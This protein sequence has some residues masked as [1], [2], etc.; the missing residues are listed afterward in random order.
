MFISVANSIHFVEV[1]TDL[2]SP[3]NVLTAD[4]K[5]A[6]YTIKTYCQRF[7]NTD[8]VTVQ[9]GSDEATVPT[10]QV[11]MPHLE[12]TIVPTLV[13]SYTTDPD[14]ANH[15]Y[16]FEFDV[17]F[18]SYS[19]A[20]QIKATQG[21]SVWISEPVKAE[22]L[23]EDLANGNLLRID[24]TNSSKPSD[25]FNFEID[26]TTG[27]QFFF[28][29]EAVLTNF[30]YP[31]EDTLTKNIDR[32]KLLESKLSRAAELKTDQLPEYMC[33]LL[34]VAASHF[35]YTI[36]GLQYVLED[37]D[38]EQVE[39]TNF[40]VLTQTVSQKDVLAFNTD[41]RGIEGFDMDIVTFSQNNNVTSTWS[42]T[43]EKERMTHVVYARHNASSVATYTFKAGTTIGGNDLISD[44]ISEVDISDKTTWR[45]FPLHYY[46]GDSNQTIYIEITGVGAIADFYVPKLLNQ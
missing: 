12:A 24:H 25:N 26:Y 34:S 23:T 10:V 3:E 4:Q 9:L 32:N 40:Q 15:R 20:I 39:F 8:T 1:N 44:F 13:S 11:F 46:K 17:V 42:F 38:I 29:V 31:R 37:D 35:Y 36:N 14:T 45:R 41:N 7:K 28:Y 5:R 22:D 16:Y 33:Q 43:I 6:G 27:I 30:N 19:D 21:N 18:S 2:P